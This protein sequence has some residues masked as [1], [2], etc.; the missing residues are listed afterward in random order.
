MHIKPP[1]GFLYQGNQ[2]EDMFAKTAAS[3]LEDKIAEGADNMA[4]F[5]AEP[6]QGA[7]GV[8]IPPPEGYFAASFKR[9]AKNMIFYLSQMR[10]SQDLVAQGNGLPARPLIYAPI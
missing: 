2:S 5:V 1:Y 8:I 3:W 4:A 7:G 6:I 10:S 9:F